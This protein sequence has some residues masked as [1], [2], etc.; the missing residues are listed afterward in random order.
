MKKNHES[1]DAKNIALFM[2]LISICTG[3]GQRY[4]PSKQAQKIS[5]LQ[6]LLIAVQS[7]H[8]QAIENKVANT[9]ATDERK[10][11][12]KN[13]KKFARQITNA[14]DANGAPDAKVENAKDIVYKLDGKRL[15]E[16][17]EPL[18]GETPEQRDARIISHRQTGY[19]NMVKHF[20]TLLAILKSEPGYQPN[21]QE[22]SI[23]GVAAKLEQISTINKRV[24]DTGTNSTN[25]DSKLFKLMYETDT[26]MVDIANDV[27]KYVKSVFGAQSPEYKQLSKLTFRKPMKKK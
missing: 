15:T 18:P 16:L 10:P 11:V 9:N 13:L 2:E 26:G 20:T 12:F 19:D 23:D 3:F 21:E 24:I 1:G 8:V 14:L 4:N 6:Q 25:S 27:K 7:G 17:P 5:A 22:L